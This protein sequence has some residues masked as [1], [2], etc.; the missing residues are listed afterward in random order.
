MTT[1]HSDYS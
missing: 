1:T